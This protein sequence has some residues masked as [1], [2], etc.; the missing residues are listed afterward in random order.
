VGTSL[1]FRLRY[2][3]EEQTSPFTRMVLAVS[4]PAASGQW[5][6]DPARPYLNCRER[7]TGLDQP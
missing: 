3:F 5:Q 1:S 4:Q 7:A 6:P 2:W